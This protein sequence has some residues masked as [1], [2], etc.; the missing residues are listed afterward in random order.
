MPSSRNP[1]RHQGRVA[2]RV[3]GLLVFPR[4]H[5]VIRTTHQ[6]DWPDCR[7][8]G[9]IPTLSSCHPTP[10]N[11]LAGIVAMAIRLPAQLASSPGTII[12]AMQ[13]RSLRSRRS[14]AGCNV[15]HGKEL[16]VEEAIRK[17][18]QDASESVG[19]RWDALRLDVTPRHCLQCFK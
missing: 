19:R 16:R 11:A 14:S 17:S 15:D 2:R 9:L 7:R 10:T 6:S 18:L 1:A 5:Q 13:R 8:G 12:S 4:D 3:L